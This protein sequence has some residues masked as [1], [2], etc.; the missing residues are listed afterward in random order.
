MFVCFLE[1]YNGVFSREVIHQKVQTSETLRRHARCSVCVHLR[2][3]DA[4]LEDI[5]EAFKK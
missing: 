1:L 4:N 5:K 2:Y 3:A